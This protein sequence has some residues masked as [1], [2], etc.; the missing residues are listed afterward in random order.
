MRGE[1]FLIG[2]GLKA[3]RDAQEVPLDKGL[4]PRPSLGR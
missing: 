4:L 1:V 3:D 2:V